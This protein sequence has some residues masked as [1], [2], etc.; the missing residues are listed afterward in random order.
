M[1]P[2][3][4][5]HPRFEELAADPVGV[6]SELGTY[7]NFVNLLGWC[8]V[9][10]P[11]QAASQSALGLPFGVTFIAAQSADV[12]LARWAQRWQSSLAIPMGLSTRVNEGGD[13]L[14]ARSTPV[15]EAVLSLAVVGAHLSGLP[16]NG[17][18]LERRAR[19][20]CRTRTAPRYRLHALPGTQ[21]P[22]PGLQRVASGGSGIE[23]EV[24]EMP[25]SE[26]GSFLS[27][28][29]APLG[30]GTIELENGRH[31]HGFLCEAHA[32]VE[33]PDVSHHGG[34]RAY[35]AAQKSN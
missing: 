1:V 9:A 13:E 22:K 6:N 27:L 28:I 2:T 34:W 14:P 26:V 8:A 11:A 25:M 16:L 32:L 15:E 17:Q 24:W 23:L 5:R 29:P 7:T 30:L 12:A 10:V 4:P 18:L 33:A 20:Q 3:A 31:V 21:P 19:L 35:L